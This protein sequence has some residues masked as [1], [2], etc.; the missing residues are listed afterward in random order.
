M[1]YSPWGSVAVETHF[2]VF[3]LKYQYF[4]RFFEGTLLKIKFATTFPQYV[5]EE[6]HSFGRCYGAYPCVTTLWCSI[7][8]AK[9]VTF[10]R[11]IL[12]ESCSKF[13]FKQCSLK[14]SLKILIFWRE[15]MEMCLHGNQPLWGIKHPIISLQSKYHSPGIIRF[16]I[17]LAPV[18]SSLDEIY[19]KLSSLVGAFVRVLH[20]IYK[21]HSI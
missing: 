2:H 14:K 17:M 12:S 8:T 5:L 18:M 3:S 13:D 7:A 15:F 21:Q 19:C 4:E 9:Q 10:L 11:N 6:Y 1:L 20:L 16:F